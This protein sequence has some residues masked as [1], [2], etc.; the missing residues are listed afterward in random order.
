[1][2]HTT[3]CSVTPITDYSN[4]SFKGL[5]KARFD[6]LILVLIWWV[7]KQIQEAAS[8]VLVEGGY[9]VGV[10]D[11]VFGDFADDELSFCLLKP[12]LRLAGPEGW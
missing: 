7:T 1:M 10:F 2:Q 11:L 4:P 6:S 8:S 5:G 9:D 3:I 12:H